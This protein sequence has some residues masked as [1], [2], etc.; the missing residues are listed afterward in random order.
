MNK[1]SARIISSGSIAILGS[2]ETSPNLV[3]VHREMI[4]RL[5][6]GTIKEVIIA[7]SATLEGQTTAHYLADRM[8]DMGLRVTQIAHGM[9]VGGELDYLDEGTISAALKARMPL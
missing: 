4:N 9:P 6:K 2:G 1:R 7:L 3:S 5:K 8:Q